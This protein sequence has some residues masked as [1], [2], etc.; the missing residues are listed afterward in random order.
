MQEDNYP[1]YAHCA[2]GRDRTGI[3]MFHLG[4][5]LGL[6][7]ETLVADYE[8]TYLSARSYAKGDLK[9]HNWMIT[10]LND[11]ERLE[12]ETYKEKAENFWLSHGITE[13]QLQTFRSIMLE[14][15]Q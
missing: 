6:S 2:A 11:F 1:V 4:A 10:F 12:G 15:V 5:L 8:M 9:G 7:K 13:E 3:L 14:Q